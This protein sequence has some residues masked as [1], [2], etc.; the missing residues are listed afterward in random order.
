M[1]SRIFFWLP[2]SGHKAYLRQ[3]VW[4]VFQTF[5][6]FEFALNDGSKKY[7]RKVNVS[8]L[9][10]SLKMMGNPIEVIKENN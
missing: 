2:F 9:P 8:R 5:R 4:N 6:S 10:V 3:A 7:N 1:L